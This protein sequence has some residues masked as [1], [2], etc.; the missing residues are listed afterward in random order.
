[1][2]A[3]AAGSLGERGICRV[4]ELPQFVGEGVDIALPECAGHD[5]GGL[6]IHLDGNAG[7]LQNVAALELQAY[8]LHARK[9]RVELATSQVSPA[10]NVE[11]PHGVPAWA[12]D[13]LGFLLPPAVLC[14]LDAEMSALDTRGKLVHAQPVHHKQVHD[15]RV[16][17]DLGGNSTPGHGCHQPFVLSRNPSNKS[18]R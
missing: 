7:E 1:M 12:A 9:Q 13:D 15:G 11:R 17:H 5:P 6:A 16:G 14:N 10:R 2:C 3:I 4:A 8:E 18:H